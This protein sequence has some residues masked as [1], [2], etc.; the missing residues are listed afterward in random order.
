MSDD[1]NQVNQNSSR[2]AFLE[3]QVATLVEGLRE[4]LNAIDELN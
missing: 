2:I 1:R 4:L 3:I